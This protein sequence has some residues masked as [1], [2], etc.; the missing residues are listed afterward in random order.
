[1]S[2]QEEIIRREQQQA[3][4]RHV[5]EHQAIRP[6]TQERRD[7]KRQLDILRERAKSERRARALQQA[8]EFARRRDA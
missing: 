5:E 1:M 7:V 6:P 4:R 2:L 3:L 8:D